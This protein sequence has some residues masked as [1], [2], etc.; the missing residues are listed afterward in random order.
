MAA[1]GPV[2]SPGATVPAQ[3]AS[4]RHG[5]PARAPLRY[6]GLS[7]PILVRRARDGDSQALETLCGRH[8]P[9]VDRLAAHVL[10]DREDARDAA[11]DALAKLCPKIGQFRGEAA[12]STW[13]HRLTLNAC[14]DVAQRRRAAPT[15]RSPRT[16][17]PG[18]TTSPSGGGAVGA[19][20]GSPRMG[21]PGLPETQARVLVLKDALGFS[22][23]E[24]S[25]AAGIPVGTAKCYAHRGRAAMREA[26]EAGRDVIP[27]TPFGKAEIEAILPHRDPF[28]LL[29]EVVELEPGRK[30][31]ATRL[32]REDDWWFPGHF[33]E[34]PGDARRADR[35]G[36]GAGGRGRR[37]RRGGEPGQDRVLR[38]HRRLSLQARRLARARR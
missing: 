35:R 37:S 34:R 7:D 10:A 36:D 3:E 32:V 23:A 17:A 38:G 30:V 5:P 13:L 14:R 28:L 22:F 26:L 11:Q 15:T 2:D 27:A 21:S 8:A 25:A 6:E 18:A 12:F 24:I 20:R 29:D 4:N 33:P 16:P 1:D 9:R 19:A 31:V